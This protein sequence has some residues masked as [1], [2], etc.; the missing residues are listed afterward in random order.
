[1]PPAVYDRI[2]IGFGKENAM[3]VL[4]YMFG[5]PPVRVGGLVRYATDLMKQELRIGI[6]VR[7]LIP[8]AIPGNGRK[9]TKVRKSK[10]D[11]MQIP[12]YLIDH[13]LPVAMCNGILDIKSYTEKCD[14]RVFRSFLQELRPNLI[15]IHTFMGLH[16]EFLNEVQK[17]GIPVLFTTHD[18]FGICP[19]AVM[20]Q[21]GHLCEDGKWKNC[22]ACCVNAFSKSRL[23]LEQSEI[24]RLVRKQDRIITLFKKVNNQISLG[25]KNPRKTRSGAEMQKPDY[26]ALRKYYAS[27]F[28]MVSWFHFNSTLS[29]KIY[30]SRLEFIKGSV[31]NISH[32]GIADQRKS[33]I[34]KK[35]LRL[36]YFGSWAVH[37]GFYLLLEVCGSL[38]E[39]G[40]TNL[41]LHLYSDTEARKEVFVRNHPGFRNE[42]LDRIFCD[43]DVLV[44]PSIWP[45][46]FGLV[47]L[48]AV[49]YGVPVIIS[50]YT[51][52]QDILPGYQKTEAYDEAMPMNFGSGFI[53]DGTCQGLKKILKTIYDHRELLKQANNCIVDMDYDFSYEIHVQ[54]MIRMYR[55][56]IKRKAEGKPA[57]NSRRQV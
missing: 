22:A 50:E 54:E 52:A 44:V 30:E 45:E 42:Q 49:S 19:T 8:G 53:Y 38:Y 25:R 34:Y 40:C 23:R 13:P 1:M 9:K 12:V 37:K 51:G 55:K 39:E 4:H 11:Y 20:L 14:G 27:M 48:E 31:I 18:Y 47:V 6:D 21:H 7:L 15:H 17:L 46:T 10:K 41:E 28:R 29:K 5:I 24:Y 43:I 26:A 16:R 33:R 3:K 2:F 36:G 35:E 32:S 57:E 56:L